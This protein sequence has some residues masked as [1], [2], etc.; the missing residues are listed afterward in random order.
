MFW[1]KKPEPLSFVQISN[2]LNGF[3]ARYRSTLHANNIHRKTIDACV[4]TLLASLVAR[5][6]IVGS[7][8]WNDIPQY[9]ERRMGKL[10][11]AI[12]EQLDCNFE[13]RSDN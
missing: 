10:N 4:D 13:P 7:N 8:E 1:R 12:H 6:I 11:S 2:D 9:V 3:I 5:D